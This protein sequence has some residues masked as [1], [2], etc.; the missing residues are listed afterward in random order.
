MNAVETV[1]PNAVVK[2]SDVTT[3]RT[4]FADVVWVKTQQF[5]PATMHEVAVFGDAGDVKTRVAGSVHTCRTR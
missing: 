4:C 2:G 5:M 3:C 1:T